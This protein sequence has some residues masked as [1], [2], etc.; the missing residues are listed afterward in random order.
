LEAFEWRNGW[1]SGKALFNW[2][3][4]N[5]GLNVSYSTF[6][7][8]LGHRRRNS[9]KPVVTPTMEEY[10]AGVRSG[11]WPVQLKEFGI[12]YR[13]SERQARKKVCNWFR[14]AAA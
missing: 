11:Q 4:I 12:R 1:G 9:R 3:R 6:L 8:Y 7:A 2:C 13:R 10:L 14:E 5:V